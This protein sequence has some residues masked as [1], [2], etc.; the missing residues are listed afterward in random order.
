MSEQWLAS[1][2]AAISRKDRTETEMR[3]WLAERE[4]EP[5]EIESIIA[6]LTE[7]LALDDRRF[8]LA[9]AHDKRELSGWG[10]DRIREVLLKRG[11]DRELVDE[12]L[13]GTGGSDGGVESE[14]ERA[15]RVLNERGADLSDDRGRQRALGLLARRGYE[16]EEAY[17]AIRIAERAA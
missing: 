15:V 16:A 2:L 7:N 1:A 17:A 6:C 12:A 9:Y 10:K 14:V 5:D 3:D 8:A 13:A 11:V 4:V